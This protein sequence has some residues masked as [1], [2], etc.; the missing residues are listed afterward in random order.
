MTFAEDGYGAAVAQLSTAL[1]SLQQDMQRLHLQQQKLLREPRPPP[2]GH[3]WV[4]PPRPKPTPETP[5][6]PRP[7]PR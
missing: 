2:G 7:P 3:A 1:S 4:I 5:P 6:L